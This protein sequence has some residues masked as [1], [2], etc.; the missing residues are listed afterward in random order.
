MESTTST[1][2]WSLSRSQGH[3]ESATISTKLILCSEGLSSKYLVA[4]LPLLL[5][6]SDSQMRLA[7]T[8]YSPYI[9]SYSLFNDSQNGN[10]VARQKWYLDIIA[11]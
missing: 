4:S 9:L 8:I 1:L 6:D 3:I 11:L 2:P 10:D 5:F 7:K